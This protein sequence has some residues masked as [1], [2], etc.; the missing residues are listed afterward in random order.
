[1]TTAIRS[2]VEEYLAPPQP[3]NTPFSQ[4]RI[5]QKVLSRQLLGEPLPTIR[6][7]S[8]AP[9]NPSDAEDGGSSS[10]TLPPD[11]PTP[12]LRHRASAPSS[13]TLLN[14]ESITEETLDKHMY[15]AENPPLDIFIRTSGVERL[16]DFMLWQ[17]H[18]DTQIFFLE[19]L[20][21]EFDLWHFIPVL[22][23]WQWRQ[24]QK[25]RDEQPHTRGRIGKSRKA[26]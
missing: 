24:K 18:Q 10:A 21:P 7:T 22:L 17:C 23:E 4:S 14:P 6:D 3:K 26:V 16:S 11:S 8:P 2:T 20:W 13:Q 1:M 5:T 19:C 12:A 25:E 9:S 15:T